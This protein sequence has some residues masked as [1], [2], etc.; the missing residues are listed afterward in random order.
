[1]SCRTISAYQFVLLSVYLFC[2]RLIVMALKYN[3]KS[4]IL[5]LV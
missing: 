2:V 5:V 1:M 3:L 4:W